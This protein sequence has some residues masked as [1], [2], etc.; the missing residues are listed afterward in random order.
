LAGEPSPAAALE[1]ERQL[2]ELTRELARSATEAAYNRLEPDDPQQLPSHL[3]YDAGE[4]RRLNAKTPNRHVATLFGKITLCTRPHS[5][6]EVATTATLSIHDRKGQRLGTVY[7]AYAP[8]LGQQTNPIPTQGAAQAA[9]SAHG[10][11][12]HLAVEGRP[13]SAIA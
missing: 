6:F 8:E 7:L 2:A 11:A 3:H 4:Y 10:A 1:F 13:C 12:T 9:A 5:F